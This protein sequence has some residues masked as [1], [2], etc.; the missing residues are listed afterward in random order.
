MCNF[1]LLVHSKYFLKKIKTTEFNNHVDIKKNLQAYIQPYSLEWS[2]STISIGPL[3]F[4]QTYI[5]T[6]LQI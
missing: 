4:A 3:K 2:I 6:M 5:Q 1:E